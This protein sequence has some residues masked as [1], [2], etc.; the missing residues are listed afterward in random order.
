MPSRTTSRWSSTLP[1][2]SAAEAE[3]LA[4]WRADTP[5]AAARI[6]LNNAGAAL[7]P[8]PVLAAVLAHLEAEAELGGY[9]AAEAA[10]DLVARAYASV[11]RLLG[12]P[13]ERIALAQSSTVAFAQA[14]AAFDLGAGD[15]VLTSQADYASNQIMYLSLARRRGVELARAA[16]LPEGGIDPDDVRRLVA[17][18]RPALVALTWIPTNSGMVQDVEAVGAVCREAGV[19]FLVDACQAVG[20][21]PIDVERIGCDY[22]AATARKFLRGPRGIGFLYVAE[23][24]T[25]RG[26]YPLLVDMR[27]ATWTEADAFALAEG[28]RRFETWEMSPA[29]V[30]GLG[31]A[32]DYALEVGIANARDRAWRL[33]EHAR[34]RLATVPGARVLDRGRARSAIATAAFDGHE[35]AALKL[36]LRARGINTSSP[37]R[38][39]AVID[40]DRKGVR[41]GLRVSPHY[42]NTDEEV[43]GAVEAI[44]ELTG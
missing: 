27:G 15:L 6:H 10:A 9:E 28:A 23:R 39:D 13:P 25:R 26:D 21:L 5:G 31:A 12:T 42:Y 4:R 17:R 36:A 1:S 41:S 43:D 18:R 7:P 32:A 16:D 22:L 37:D 19:P 20:Q 24:A 2:N 30:L 33:A 8:R 3:R 34:E 29:L 11:G 38:A 14:L 35:G 44:R 40:M